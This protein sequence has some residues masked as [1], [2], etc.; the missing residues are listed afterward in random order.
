MFKKASSFLQEKY[1]IAVTEAS[2]LV[3]MKVILVILRTEL[4]RTYTG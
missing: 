3:F 2:S 1:H 4:T